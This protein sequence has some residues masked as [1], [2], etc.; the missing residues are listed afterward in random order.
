MLKAIKKADI[1]DKFSPT[2]V[3][4]KYRKVKKIEFDEVGVIT[5]VPKKVRDLDKVLQFN[6]F[7]T[8]KSELRLV[9]WKHGLQEQTLPGLMEVKIAAFD[10]TF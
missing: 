7:P 8:K 1:N 6:L 5:E 3:L 2:D 4:F 10:R 9:L